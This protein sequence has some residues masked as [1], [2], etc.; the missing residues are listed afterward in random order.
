MATFE[1]APLRLLV[2]EDDPLV[3]RTLG[4]F[5]SGFGD[6]TIVHDVR[7]ARE[8]V[9]DGQSWDGAIVDV[10]LPDGSGLDLLAELRRGPLTGPALVLTGSREPQV[11]ASAQLRRAYF[12]PKP[13]HRENIESFVMEAKKHREI[14]RSKLEDR[15]SELTK[16]ILLTPREQEILRLGACGVPRSE[17][18]ARLQVEESTVKS[19]VRKLIRKTGHYTLGELVSG[20]HRAVFIEEQTRG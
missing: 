3:A 15:I 4:R 8:A 9:C 13:P 2:V 7:G 11:I 19:T 17:L 18:A 1:D 14:V 5:L 6:V 12:L 16:D 10:G 20:I